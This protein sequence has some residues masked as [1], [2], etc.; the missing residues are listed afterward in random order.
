MIVIYDETAGTA[1]EL[2][3]ATEERL[4]KIARDAHALATAVAASILHDVG[5]DDEL[6]HKAVH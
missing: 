6:A 1:R 3:P 5:L 4:R 2:D